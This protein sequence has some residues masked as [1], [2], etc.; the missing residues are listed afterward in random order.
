MK[1]LEIQKTK[2][3]LIISVLKVDYL[4]PFLGLKKL[5]KQ[6]IGA[7]FLFPEG[8]ANTPFKGS[9]TTYTRNNMGQKCE[10]NCGLWLLNEIILKI[11]LE[12]LKKIVGAVWEL[13]A[14]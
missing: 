4:V 3:T 12:N 9:H 8:L 7:T 1:K 13:L 2:P 10:G 11:Y 5:K 6:K 14:K